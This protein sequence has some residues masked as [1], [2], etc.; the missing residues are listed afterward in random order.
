MYDLELPK[1]LH[2]RLVR[3]LY[4]SLRLDQNDYNSAKTRFDILI[5]LL[6]R[7]HLERKD[8]C[9]DP[10]ILIELIENQIE[11]NS[12]RMKIFPIP[13]SYQSKLNQLVI[14]SRVY[15]DVNATESILQRWSQYLCIH[16]KDFNRYLCYFS[17]FL[18]TLLY[19]EE[20]QKGFHS[21]FQDF[22][23]L[24]LQIPLSKSKLHKPLIILFARLSQTACGYIDWQP[25]LLEI[26]Q[27]FDHIVKNKL[28]DYKNLLKYFLIWIVHLIDP[29]SKAI[30]YLRQIIVAL[31][32][33]N[34]FDKFILSSLPFVLIHRYQNESKKNCWFNQTP[35]ESLLTETIIREL[36]SSIQQ[37]FFAKYFIRQTRIESMLLSAL[38]MTNPIVFADLIEENLSIGCDDYSRPNFFCSILHLYASSVYSI[39]SDDTIGPKHRLKLAENLYKITDTLG[40]HNHSAY[41]Q[42]LSAIKS[43]VILEIPFFDFAKMSEA[44]LIS[45]LTKFEQKFLKQSDKLVQFPLYF[46]DRCLNLFE[47]IGEN[48]HLQEVFSKDFDLI[49]I[50][51]F[52]RCPHRTIEEIIDKIINF[53]QNNS[54][55]TNFKLFELILQNLVLIYPEKIMRKFFP[56][57]LDYF[58]VLPERFDLENSSNK[59]NKFKYNLNILKKMFKCRCEILINY[60]EQI[61]ELFD[62]ICAL[63]FDKTIESSIVSVFRQ[64]LRSS[65]A[66]VIVPKIQNP[67]FESIRFENW[68]K[69][70][71]F[72]QF[73]TNGFKTTE[74]EQKLAAIF[75]K[76]LS[77]TL[78]SLEESIENDANLSMNSL[79]SKLKLLMIIEGIEMHIPFNRDSVYNQDETKQANVDDS[80]NPFVLTNSS[81]SIV[82]RRKIVEVCSKILTIIIQKNDIKMDNENN[83]IIEC[84]LD[85]YSWILCAPKFKLNAKPNSIISL[86][87]RFKLSIF[88]YFNLENQDKIIKERLLELISKNQASNGSIESMIVIEDLLKICTIPIYKNI[89]KKM[90]LIFKNVFATHSSVLWQFKDLIKSYSEQ[91]AE[92]HSSNSFE[93][94]P[95]LASP[96]PR[97][98]NFWAYLCEIYPS[99][100]KISIPEDIAE[101]SNI[102]VG[103]EL[104]DQ[105][106]ANKI[107]LRRTLDWTIVKNF[108][109]LRKIDEPAVTL[110]EFEM[111]NEEIETKNRQN[112]QA[113]RSLINQIIQTIQ[114]DVVHWRFCYLGLRFLNSLIQKDI[115]IE[116]E[117]VEFYLQCLIH[118]LQAIRSTAHFG[119]CKIIFKF[120]K[121]NEIIMN[122]DEFDFNLLSDLDNEQIF[123]QIKYIDD[124][125]N[126]FYRIAYRITTIDCCSPNNLHAIIGRKFSDPNF[127]GQY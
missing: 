58:A 21:W 82:N 42:I 77:S 116:T 44:N 8:L 90:Y 124:A 49:L 54:N 48:K 32:F 79:K 89:K 86:D 38:I 47:I 17:L 66:T 7:K 108:E 75:I 36:G 37:K 98:E 11:T 110:D 59:Q 1:Q 109:N 101:F 63:G 4:E 67:N 41:P 87:R 29:R 121:A 2:L 99:F 13:N 94:L 52:I 91:M 28:N 51:M 65:L 127:L 25:Y 50:S 24:W 102:L 14:I 16:C 10:I 73:E 6:R 46:I 60:Q 15:F 56:Y 33:D 69:L 43:I 103:F 126:G 30:D 62:R 34:K 45:S 113:Y 96:H 18:P 3:M 97:M 80:V 64:L 26:F 70:I 23:S 118:D 106:I 83:E 93:I 68:P 88:H 107:V 53:Y 22:F 81:N 74:K 19:P 39:I 115:E 55:A 111:I 120:L 122:W 95:L 76:K 100:L 31:N 112:N 40:T 119:F 92:D 105:S 72:D 71:K 57:L 123:N 85:I 61:M 117:L 125:S 12:N 78:Y 5:K 84:V 9:L 114:N 35:S 104:F 27:R 20:H